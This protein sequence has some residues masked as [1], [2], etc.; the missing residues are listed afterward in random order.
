[1]A[2]GKVLTLDEKIE[3][4]QQELERLQNLKATEEIKK[5]IFSAVKDCDDVAKLNKVLKL[6]APQ[7]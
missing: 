7:E 2:R 3:K 4:A 6:L 5:Q 1:M